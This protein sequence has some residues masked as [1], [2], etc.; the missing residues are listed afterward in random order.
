MI[1]AT[2]QLLLTSYQGGYIWDKMNENH[3][4]SVGSDAN[5][6]KAAAHRVFIPEHYSTIEL[7]GKSY[8]SWFSRSS[9]VCKDPDCKQTED[10]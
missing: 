10:H 9:R 3:S 6:K 1:V 2:S 4:K 7:N 5:D 8:T